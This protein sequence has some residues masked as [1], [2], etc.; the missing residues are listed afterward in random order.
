VLSYRRVD[1]AIARIE[2]AVAVGV[3]VAM[4]LV[5]SLQALFFNIAERNVAW[6]QSML[7][8][9]D[10]ADAFLQKGTLWLAFIG[11]SLATYHDKH[12]AIDVLPRL[13]APPLR[14]V[15]QIVAMTGAGAVAFLLAKVFYDACLV[16]DQSVPFEYEV[17]TARGPTHVCDASS[18]ELGSAS[19]PML[20]CGVRGAF[21]AMGVPITSGGGAA[22]LITPLMFLVIGV[23]LWAR[24][25][26]ALLTPPGETRDSELAVPARADASEPESAS[27]PE[28]EKPGND[29][30]NED[31]AA[32]SGKKTDES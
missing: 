2:G 28:A 31:E 27:E 24:A 29:A 20:L 26:I 13:V 17:L 16:A 8:S 12:I 15:M 4:V 3:L 23:R 21:A 6:A 25:V 11:A 10:W 32:K 7:E 22:Q 1:E 14:R 18:A 9:L 5:A 30:P 19:A